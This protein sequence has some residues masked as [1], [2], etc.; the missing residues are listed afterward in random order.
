MADELKI[1]YKEFTLEMLESFKDKS[2]PLLPEVAVSIDGVPLEE[3]DSE[4]KIRAGFKVMRFFT[5]EM[6]GF[7]LDSMSNT[8]DAGAS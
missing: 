5:T 2:K 1:E 7:P 3:C 8:N 4:T 6:K